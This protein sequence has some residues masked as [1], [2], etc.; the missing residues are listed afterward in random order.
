M[1]DKLKGIIVC[2]VVVGALGATLG[3]MK[4]TGMDAPASDDSSS[5]SPTASKAEEP[6]ESVKLIDVQPEDV[7][8]ITVINGS[9][10][11]TYLASDESGKLGAHIVE[12]KGLEQSS[13]KLKDIAEDTSQLTAKKL[14]E[15]GASDLAKYGFDDPAA[16]F[17]VEFADGTER[18]FLVG[19]AAPQNRYRYL[20]EKPAD[21]GSTADVYMVLNYTLSNFIER[22][23]DLLNMTLLKQ[24]QESVTFGKLTVSR[25]DLDYDMVFENDNGQYDKSNENMPSAQVMTEP[26]FSYLNGTSSTDVMTSLYGLTAMSAEV[27]FPDEKALAEYGLDDPIAVVTFVGDDYDY[28]LS[29]GNSYQEENATGELQTAASAYYCTFEG[30]EGKDCIWKVDATALPWANLVPEDI[31]TTLMTWNM[32]TDLSEIDISGSASAKFEITSAGE[33]LTSVKIDGSDCDVDTFK[34]LYQYILSC[35]T[36]E[37]WFDDPS[38]EPYLTIDI[39]RADGG[40]DTIEFYKDTERRSIVKLNS[41]TS[42]RIPTTWSDRFVKNIDAVKTGGEIVEDY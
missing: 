17:T 38:G 34:T 21:G 30:V 2:A 6:D 29:I 4:L 37:I 14:V 5:K 26:I 22:K 40:G 31:I 28:K 7:Q 35:P 8:K 18:T 19:A 41:R 9:G 33:D 10:G 27:I 3:I 23:E 11:Y 16:E 15:S 1:N 36:A 25:K 39:K 42:Y 24:P 12:L 20:C 13:D 32:V